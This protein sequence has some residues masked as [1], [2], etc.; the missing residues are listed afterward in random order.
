MSTKEKK[1]PYYLCIDLK[2]FYA[3]VECVDR[4]LDPMA[5]DLVVADESRTDRTI[6]LAVSPSLKA[7]GVRNRC[8]LFEVPAQLRAK[9]I[10]AQPRM[11]RYIQKSAEIYGVYL[12]WL[13]PDD[14][15]VYSIDEAFMDVTPYLDLYGCTAR[16]LGERIRADV[17]RT[18]G[19]PATCGLGTNL[20]LAKIALDITAKH[21]PDFFGELDEQSYRET[22]WNHQPITDFWRI[23]PGIARRLEALGI[24]TMGQLALSP[25]EPIY[26]ALGID[27]EILIDH[28]W[29]IE[30][31]RITDI[32]AYRSQSHSLSNGQVLSRDY[33]Y[34]DTLLIAKEM[35]DVLL[36]DLVGQGLAARSLT[37]GVGYSA[38]SEERAAARKAARGATTG[39]HGVTW[40]YGRSF[41]HGSATFVSHTSSRTEIMDE[42][43]KLFPQ[44][45]DPM[46]AVRRVMVSLNDVV[47]SEASGL[48]L[49]LFADPEER[50]RE[51]RR[52]QAINAVHE[53][54]GKNALLHAMDLLPNATARER[55]D[56]IG[57]HRRG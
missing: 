29:G 45:V 47:P 50:E 12:K 37:L 9:T 39:E 6:C 13:S 49:D 5:T 42:L 14:I 32:K 51:L 52:Q 57:G 34:E 26:Q 11:S 22:L 48:Q 30:P 28:A 56:Q 53:R 23:G 15:H 17:A 7:K 44:V 36:E 16:E 19:I 46:R 27:A 20:Y 24:T 43:V 55:N 25:T 35:V 1:T 33:A 31:V 4:R 18:T 40:H 8:R 2:S 54:F 38:S 10:V 21:S 41:A 3:S